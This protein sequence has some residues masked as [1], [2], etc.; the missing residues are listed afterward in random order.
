MSRIKLADS[1]PLVHPLTVHIETT[2]RCNFKCRY[3][4]ESLDNYGDLVGGMQTMS[5][6]DFRTICSQLKKL[7]TIS[8]VRLWIM[9]EPLLNPLLP[10]FIRVLKDFDGDKIAERV[11]VTTNASALT[12]EK[13]RLLLSSPLDVLKISIYG[14]GDS[15]HRITQSKVGSERILKN[16]E[17]FRQLRESNSLSKLKMVIQMVDPVNKEE[18]KKFVDSYRHLADELLINGAHS[19]TDNVPGSILTTTYDDKAISI[20]QATH[21]SVK[22]LCCPFPFYTLA[23]HVNGDVST[24][25][26]DW[27]KKLKIGNIHENSLSEIWAGERLKDIQLL[28]LQ[29][30]KDSIPACSKCTYHHNNCPENIDDSR[31]EILSRIAS[32]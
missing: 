9:G 23:I 21:E 25:C 27:D 19:W 31:V 20:L 1:I 15:H 2:N 16:I 3:C 7:G 22:K 18:E 14:I 17:I 4:P 11:E 8:V 30:K 28:H 29:E 12:E 26:V 6:V 24:C 10:E 32:L 5:M 13:S